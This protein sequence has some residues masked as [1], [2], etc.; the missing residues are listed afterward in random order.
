MRLNSFNLSVGETGLLVKTDVPGLKAAVTKAVVR[1]RAEILNHL[2]GHPEFRWSLEPLEMPAGDVPELVLEMYRAGSRAGVGPFAAV[3]GAI[4]G[5]AVRAAIEGGATKAFVENG[6]DLCLYGEEEFLVGIHA[7][8]S[9]LSQRVG[10]EVWP[11]RS[12]AGLCTSSSSV[13]ESVSFGEAD[14][15]VVYSPTSPALADASATAIC[16]EIRGEEGVETGLKRAQE[17][18]GIGV[19]IIRGER[20]AAWG[21]LPGLV[22]LKPGE[23]DL[24]TRADLHSRAL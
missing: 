11:G 18:G 15:V 23:T 24:V 12:F 10:L 4:A 21:T 22:A 3:A 6:G 13:G 16:N 20:L 14:A 1:A 5:V 17:I 19:L 9:P 7:G 2:E 8:D